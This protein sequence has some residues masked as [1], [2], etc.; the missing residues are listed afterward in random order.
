MTKAGDRLAA[1]TAGRGTGAG[2]DGSPPITR[3]DV[4]PART[5]EAP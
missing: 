5:T 3:P 1:I 4:N 2:P